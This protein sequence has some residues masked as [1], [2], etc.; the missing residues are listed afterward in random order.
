MLAYL[1]GLGLVVLAE[2]VA[3]H[4]HKSKLALLR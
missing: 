4:P 1:S 2:L 3:V